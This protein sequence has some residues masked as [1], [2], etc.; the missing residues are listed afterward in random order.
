MY[1]RAMRALVI[2]ATLFIGR[3]IVQQLAA[4]GHDVT[5]AHRP[6]SHDLGPAIHNVQVDRG[7]LPS[8]ARV[9]QDGRFDAVFD[10]AYDWQ[11]G[12]TAAQVEA[13]ARSCKEGLHS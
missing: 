9:L 12:T 8:L 10:V 5:V 7:D 2:G 13:A 6:Q 11:K 3:E 1:D 4:R